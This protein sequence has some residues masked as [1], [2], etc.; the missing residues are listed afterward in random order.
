MCR[1][2]DASGGEVVAY[3]ASVPTRK[4]V[5]NSAPSNAARAERATMLMQ[6]KT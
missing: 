4:L 6:H 3:L 1:G 5:G 2:V